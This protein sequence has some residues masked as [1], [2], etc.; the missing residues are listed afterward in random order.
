MRFGLGGFYTPAALRAARLAQISTTQL[1]CKNHATRENRTPPHFP[2]IKRHAIHC[3]MT[4]LPGCHRWRTRHDN[5]I[6][7][8]ST[9]AAAVAH[10]SHAEHGNRWL[11][12]TISKTMLALLISFVGCASDLLVDDTLILHDTHNFG[13]NSSTLYG[14]KAWLTL[15]G[16]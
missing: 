4:R 12:L 5:A 8:A 7:N 11:G 14:Q 15:V 3:S 2:R 1:K 16:S 9:A 6:H 13:T 10:S